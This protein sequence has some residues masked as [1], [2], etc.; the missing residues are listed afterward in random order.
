MKKKSLMEDK[1][2]SKAQRPT[3]V[4]TPKGTF[5]CSEF[6]VEARNG[7]CSRLATVVR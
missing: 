7:G 3:L 5:H 6:V 4:G 1:R 2:N